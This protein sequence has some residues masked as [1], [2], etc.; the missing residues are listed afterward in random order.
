MVGIRQQPNDTVNQKTTICQQKQIQ[1]SKQQVNKAT[2]KLYHSFK[3]IKKTVLCCE[4]I[5]K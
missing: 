5:F 2:I 4:L 3:S 1:I